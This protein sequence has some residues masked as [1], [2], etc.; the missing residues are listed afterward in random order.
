MFYKMLISLLWAYV[1]FDWKLN[2]GA[3]AVPDVAAIETGLN[4]NYSVPQS[5]ARLAVF[6]QPFISGSGICIL[7][8]CAS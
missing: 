8:G 3:W 5:Q 4:R 7:R 2:P 6:T 1:G